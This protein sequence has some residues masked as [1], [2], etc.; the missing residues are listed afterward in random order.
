VS[1]GPS[2]W[3]LVK[4]SPGLDLNSPYCYLLLCSHFCETCLVAESEGA[5]NGF[6]TAYVPPGRPDT[7]FLWQIAVEAESKGRGL[8]RR[9]VDTL[10][11]RLPEEI[12]F[13]E[14]TVT[15]ANTASRSLFQAVA[16]DKGTSLTESAF[17]GPELFPPGGSDPS[18]HEPELLIRVGPMA[19]MEEMN[20]TS[21]R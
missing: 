13:L 2:I 3:H 16:R 8:G 9:L 12:A 17:F 19:E 15:P 5:L 14:A 11:D 18:G 21:N 6:V 4:R 10:L 20:R 7:I 1:D